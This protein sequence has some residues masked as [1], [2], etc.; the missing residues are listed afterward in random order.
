MNLAPSK[1]R[2]LVLDRARIGPILLTVKETSALTCSAAA[3]NPQLT[4][5]SGEDAAKPGFQR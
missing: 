1:T 5:R 4:P 3:C 2:A